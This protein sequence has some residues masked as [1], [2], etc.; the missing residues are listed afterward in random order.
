[1]W[2]AVDLEISK[3]IQLRV[4]SIYSPPGD[5]NKQLRA[6][7]NAAIMPVISVQTEK[8]VVVAGDL[9]DVMDPRL[10]TSSGKYRKVPNSTL[11]H[12]INSSN[13]TEA[14]RYL[15]PSKGKAYSRVEGKVQ[16]GKFKWSAALFG[17]FSGI[18]KCSI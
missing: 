13:L 7:I 11:K 15:F 5:K 2:V 12:L 9:N 17:S 6:T 8:L 16:A 14:Y 18:R 1:M 10:D 3:G 4:L